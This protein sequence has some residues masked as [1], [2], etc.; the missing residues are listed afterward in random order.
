MACCETLWNGVSDW[1]AIEENI[2]TWNIIELIGFPVDECAVLHEHSN[3]KTTVLHYK[4]G[5]EM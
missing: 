2:Q 1:A 5:V 3:C 4:K